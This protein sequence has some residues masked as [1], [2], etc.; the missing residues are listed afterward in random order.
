MQLY[1][2]ST[3][4]FIQQAIDNQIATTLEDN[5]KRYMCHSPS[6]SEVTSWIVSLKDLA[7]SLREA[8]LDTT[9]IV[10]EY[11]LPATR[12]RLDAMIVGVGKDDRERGVIVE[13]KQ[14]KT[15]YKCDIENSVVFSP[16]DKKHPRPHPSQQ[17]GEY[18]RHL[19]LFH[20]AFYT[21]NGT[22]DFVDLKACSFLHSAH[23]SK[24]GDL[25]DAEYSQLLTLN[26][27]FTGDQ[28][29]PLEAFLVE[30]VGKGDD[31]Q[32]LKKVIESKYIPSKKLLDHVA[33]II[34][35]NPVYALLDEQL[36]VLNI[37]MTKMKEMQSRSSKVVI[38]VEGAPGT[39]KSVIAARLVAETA[40]LGSSVR[41][42]TGSK[43]FTTTIQA[44]V[45]RKAAKLFGYFR[46][47]NKEEPNSIDVIIA[48][49][50]H[51]LREVT[52]D[53]YNRPI[54]TQPQVYELIDAARV[55]V[56]LLDKNQVVR[57]G[58]VGTPDFIKQA[59]EKRAAKVFHIELKDQYRCSGSDEYLE[60]LDY[61]FNLGGK[62]DVSWKPEYEFVICDSPAELEERITE[63]HIQ[64]NTARL[65]AGFCWQWSKEND[66]GTLVDDVV[67]GEW[68]KPWNKKVQGSPPPERNPYTIWATK[69]EGIEQVGCIYSAQGME[70]DYCG[71]IVGNDLTWNAETNTWQA[72]K[73]NSFD[74]PVKRSGELVS[75]LANTYRV[76]MSRGM[77][78][79]Y[80]YFLDEET[81]KH[82]IEMLTG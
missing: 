21:N 72:N 25:L 73:Q 55:S 20:P 70:F 64:G 47:F 7:Y 78:G 67:V 79:T 3:K 60:W 43:A 30:N 23:S 75:N 5:F 81:K 53:F 17:A 26:P 82:F 8:K 19:A 44:K 4:L 71:V 14:W 63:R 27:L 34:E 59:A 6:S 10:V 46:D 32:I 13:L 1:S 76:L 68:K 18:A 57:P 69:D 12:K 49:E 45:G 80:V 35:G 39:G 16:G 37:V 58:E 36:I 2:G 48:D 28:R 29:K 42:V 41:H 74:K 65:V 9:G 54:G 50:A 66:D 56:F 22:K 62:R 11:V 52:T 40:K 61:V 38:I 33:E 31:G 51:R 77:K 15:A 24:C